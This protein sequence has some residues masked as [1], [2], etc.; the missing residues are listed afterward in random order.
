ME[1]P[2]QGQV[3]KLEP[4]VSGSVDE[5]AT[6][7]DMVVRLYDTK[8]MA[9]KTAGIT[10]EQLTR[11]LKALNRPFLDTVARLCVPKGVSLDW[12]VTG[13]GAMLVKERNATA[14]GGRGS[15]DEA[16]LANLVEGLERYL[17]AK[18]LLPMPQ[19][20]A[21]MTVVF[22]RILSRWREQLA[23]SGADMPMHLR[24]AGH[25]VDIAAH[26]ILSEIV[27]LID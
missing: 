6:R 19:Q 4:R 18:D 8:T 15:L 9:A 17:A 27:S 22:Y 11:Q 1:N 20:K 5:L 16:L 14:S 23:E 7:I 10:P 2:D 25:P 13:Q 21:R 24:E 12:L 3:G 26:P